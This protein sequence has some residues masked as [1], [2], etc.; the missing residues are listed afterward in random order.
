MTSQTLAKVHSIAILSLLSPHSHEAPCVAIDPLT[1]SGRGYSYF[2]LTHTVSL[3]ST[4]LPTLHFYNCWVPLHLLN[5]ITM[6]M[7]N[8]GGCWTFVSLLYSI[9]HVPLLQHYIHDYIH[10]LTLLHTLLSY[11]YTLPQQL[12]HLIIH[13]LYLYHGL[14]DRCAEYL[15]STISSPLWE[16]CWGVLQALRSFG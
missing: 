5:L 16:E 15:V 12:L 14:G 13:T 9:W 2:S 10:R 6:D 1:L 8:E 11:Y 4:L 7:P 3:H